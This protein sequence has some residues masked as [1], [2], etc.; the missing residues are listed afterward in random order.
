ME[1]KNNPKTIRAWAMFD[2]ANSSYN[3]VIT[4]TIFPAYFTAITTTKAHGDVV[5]FFGH[6]FINT[7]LS[8]YVL[9]AAYLLVVL[10]LPILTSIAD[11]KGNKKSYMQFFTL[12]G[13]IACCGLYFFKLSTLEAGMICFGIAAI[14]YCGGFVFYNSYLPQIAT[15]DKQDAVSAKGFTYGYI[16]SVILQ[17]ICFVFVLSPKT[18]GITDATFPARLSFLL[19]GIWWMAFA[20]IPFAR[21]PKGEPNASVSPDYN[22]ISGGFK[23]LAHVWKKVRSMPLLKRYLPAFFFYSMGVQTIMLVAANFG[24]KELK[25]PEES[26]IGVILV[27]QLVAIGG[28]MLMSKLSDKYGNVKVLIGVV[29][30]WI[31]ACVAAYLTTNATQF[32]MLAV[33]VGLIMGGIQSLSRSTYSKYLPQDITDTASYFSFYDVTEKLAIVIG[34][35]CFGFV[36]SL[37]HSMRNSALILAVFFVIGLVLLFSLLSAERKSH[38]NSELSGL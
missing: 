33:V 28:A 15:L 19:V 34:L 32:Y 6:Q 8:N 2:W 3:L 18:F 20:Q 37:T 36:E 25:L 16:G 22:V 14:G 13:G 35:F 9:A 29:F 7:A 1:A 5:T 38:K 31:F 11:Y 10:M 26:L 12:M 27:I 21:L 17:I 23:E 30:I 24:A 4:S